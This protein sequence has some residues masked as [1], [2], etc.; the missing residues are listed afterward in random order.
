M[1]ASRSI[2]KW[3]CSSTTVISI[4]EATES[5]AGV[6]STEIAGIAS[7]GVSGKTVWKH[8]ISRSLTLSIRFHCLCR[9]PHL[10]IQG[11]ARGIELLSCD[12]KFAVRFG[13]VRLSKNSCIGPFFAVGT[14]GNRISRRLKR[15]NKFC[16]PIDAQIRLAKARQ[17]ITQTPRFRVSLLRIP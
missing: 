3:N 10:V 2:C 6:L 12:R 17:L 4:T 15:S 16:K 13:A 8:S 5:H 9:V 7:P 14:K 11:R 1:I